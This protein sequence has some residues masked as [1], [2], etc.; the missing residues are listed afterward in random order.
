MLVFNR[1]RVRRFPVGIVH[2]GHTLMVDLV[3]TFRF[4]MQAPIGQMAQAIAEIL[5]NGTGIDD[6]TG[7]IQVRRPFAV[8]IDASP[9]FDAFQKGVDEDI[10]A[11][12]GDAL[13]TV[14]EII[15]VESIAHGQA[16]DDECRQ[17]RT[18]PA[19]L[20]FRIAFD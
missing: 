10:V 1:P 18:A 2:D 20:F 11:P 12:F 14:V 16:L 3:I 4:K 5:V 9:H 17:V 15:I 13:P 6:F 8:I 19:P 7:Y